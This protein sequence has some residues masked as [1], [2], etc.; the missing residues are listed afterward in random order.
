MSTPSTRVMAWAAAWESCNP[1]KVAALYARD[2][3]HAS[4]VVSQLYPE[5]QASVLK[6][7]DQIR[8]YARRAMARFTTLRFE[9][10]SVVESDSSAA[11]EYLRHSNLDTDK[12]SH[13]LELIEWERERIKSVRVFHF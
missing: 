11:V 2:A 1:D 5:A 6:G 10:V 12:P 8:E 7:R 13:V 3:T 9:I 4:A